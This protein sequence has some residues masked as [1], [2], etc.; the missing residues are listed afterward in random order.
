MHQAQKI[1]HRLCAVEKIEIRAA[2]TDRLDFLAQT[3]YQADLP[4]LNADD[5][6]AVLREVKVLC[7]QESAS[8]SITNGFPCTWKF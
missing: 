1:F 2:N 3:N 6:L 4:V 5:R 7:L 8:F